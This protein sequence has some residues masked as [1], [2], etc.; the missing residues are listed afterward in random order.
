[1]NGR[2]TRCPY[3]MAWIV[4]RGARDAGVPRDRQAIVGVSITQ[5][6]FV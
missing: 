3:R 5:A 2:C 4:I 6:H 1:V